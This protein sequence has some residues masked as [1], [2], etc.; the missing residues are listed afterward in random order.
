MLQNLI[1]QDTICAPATAAGSGAIAVIRVSGPQ[2]FDIADEIFTAYDGL[3]SLKDANGYTIHFGK[4]AT[5]EQIIDEV[6]VS[7]FKNPKSYTG[8]DSLE[9]SCHGSTYIQEQILELLRAN[10]CRFADAGEF[11]MRAFMNGKFDLSQAEAVADLIASNSASSHQVAM[12]Q[13]RGGFSH[14]IK[15]LRKELVDFASLLEL[16]LDFS[17]EDV[18]FADRGKFYE[19]L[20]RIK[21]EVQKLIA[22]FKLGN[23]MKHGIPVAIIGK[24]NAGKSTL[25]NRI[26]QEEK[27]IVSDIPGTTRDAIEDTII[28]DG[29]AFRFIDTAGL[30]DSSDKIENIGIEKTYEKIN[31]SQV[32]LYVCDMTK[33]SPEELKESIADFQEHIDDEN[34]QFII[35]GNKTDELESLPSHFTDYVDLETIFISAKRNENIHLIAEK[36][37]KS[38]KELNLQDS[39]I[40]TNA[41]HVDILHKVEESILQ[42]EQALDNEIPTDLIAIDIRMALHYLG[43]ITGE[44]TTD[45]LLGNIFGKFCIGK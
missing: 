38:V 4:I 2:A 20:A 7:V 31:Q 11:T 22:S 33:S 27:A 42:V 23:V 39:T 16:E 18:E 5:K 17:E 40:V 9:I 8:E 6:L 19:L 28:I 35:I 15:E 21:G 1:K 34:K 26:L 41:R 36:L 32:I 13:M 10:G 12:K 29:F 44:V 45:E 43:E 3:K 37:V 25:L 14:Q 24:P 30:R